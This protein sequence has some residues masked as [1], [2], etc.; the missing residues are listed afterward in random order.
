MSFGGDKYSNH[1]RRLCEEELG[2]HPETNR[3][4]LEPE[5]VKASEGN[6]WFPRT[7]LKWCVADNFKKA[8]FSWV[9]VE[10]KEPGKNVEA[11]KQSNIEKPC[12]PLG[13]KKQDEETW[14]AGAGEGPLCRSCGQ[15]GS[16]Q[17]SGLQHSGGSRYFTFFLLLPSSPCWIFLLAESKQKPERRSH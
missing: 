13:L 2:P 9:W 16:Q 14:R 7:I 10:L 5:A 12:S 6:C 15:G 11:L 3:K 1:S 8:L 17:T 4:P